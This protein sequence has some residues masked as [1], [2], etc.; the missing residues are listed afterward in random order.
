MSFSNDQEKIDLSSRLQ[1][2]RI[3]SPNKH[4][5]STDANYLKRLSQC[6]FISKSNKSMFIQ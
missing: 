5:D 6:S 2:L 3:C 4:H 1:T